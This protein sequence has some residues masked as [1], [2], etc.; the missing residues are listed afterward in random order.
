MAQILER[1]C[2]HSN[3]MAQILERWCK[4]SNVMAQRFWDGVSTLRV[5]QL[6]C[7]ESKG[8]N[9]KKSRNETVLF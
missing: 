8:S 7:L 9:Q 6:L 1:L 4:H 3:A 5:A 2:K